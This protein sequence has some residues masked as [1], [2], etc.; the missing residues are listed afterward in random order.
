MVYDY[1]VSIETEGGRLRKQTQQSNIHNV[2]K[3][4]RKEY[5]DAHMFIVLKKV[6]TVG[7]K[8]VG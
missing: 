1:D 3:E 7:T 6:P 8:G 4:V 2:I 5:P